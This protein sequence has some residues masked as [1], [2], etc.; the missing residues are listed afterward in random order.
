[1]FSHEVTPP[2]IASNACIELL[3][4]FSIGGLA[5][6]SQMEAKRAGLGT[7]SPLRSLL[8]ILATNEQNKGKLNNSCHSK[9]DKELMH[10]ISFIFD[11]D[12]NRN[13]QCAT[14]MFCICNVLI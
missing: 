1:M 8:K 12:T 3:V 13:T 4:L 9:C 2:A 6:M 11:V 14:D 7:R 10:F 5:R